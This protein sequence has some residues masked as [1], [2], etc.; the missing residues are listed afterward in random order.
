MRAERLIVAAVV[1]LAAWSVVLATAAWTLYAH[2][3]PSPSF[4][5]GSSVDAGY[6]STETMFVQSGSVLSVDVEGLGCTR[7]LVAP[8]VTGALVVADVRRRHVR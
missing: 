7:I 1:A 8:T 2:P 3:I 5:P 4:V 6:R